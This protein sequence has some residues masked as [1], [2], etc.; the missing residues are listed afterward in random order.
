YWVGPSYKGLEVSAVLLECH[1]KGSTITFLYGECTPQGGGCAPPLDVQNY[2]PEMRNREKYLAGPGPT[3][4]RGTDTEVDGVPTTDF[5]SHVD[6]YFEETTVAIFGSAA[7][8]LVVAGSLV[9]AP[10]VP[11][12]LAQY[13]LFFDPECMDVADYCQADR[14]PTSEDAEFITGIVLSYGV[15]FGLPFLAAL[16][17]G[18][19]WLLVVPVLM[20]LATFVAGSL[21]WVATGENWQFFVIPTMLLAVLVTTLGLL[22]HATLA[23]ARSRPRPG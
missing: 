19:W 20:S 13:G 2:P 11:A 4:V 17:I 16:V 7:P 23:R 12:G 21:G 8:G 3:L 14:S 15:T 9:E 22:L 5:G 6:V 10:P 18:R 1:P